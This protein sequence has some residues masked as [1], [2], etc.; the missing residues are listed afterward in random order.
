M[1]DLTRGV[2]HA[3]E[4]KVRDVV[5]NAAIFVARTEL[6]EKTWCEVLD[7]LD[8]I[9]SENVWG[10]VGAEVRTDVEGIWDMTP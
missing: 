7:A 4:I 2:E 5:E 3:V 9:V 8:K 6:R 10:A 1:T